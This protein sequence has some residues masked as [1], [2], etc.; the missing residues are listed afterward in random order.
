M[1]AIGALFVMGIILLVGWFV[2]SG[3]EKVGRGIGKAILGAKSIQCEPLPVTVKKADGFWGPY[4]IV[5]IDKSLPGLTVIL[6]AS[7]ESRVHRGYRFKE[8]V[9]A[10][11]TVNLGAG[12]DWFWEPGEQ[13]LIV[14]HP[15]GQKTP[16]YYPLLFD[17][18]GETFSGRSLWLPELE[19]Y[20]EKHHGYQLTYIED[21]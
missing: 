21:R 20:F 6:A 11:T 13:L 10:G 7:H 12:E 9:P 8:G 15:P 4:V 16:T 1:R 18:N 5:S 17:F 3:P 14:N 19:E 2:V